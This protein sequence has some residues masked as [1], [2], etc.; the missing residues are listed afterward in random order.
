M[1]TTAFTELNWRSS[2]FN[3]GSFEEAIKLRKATVPRVFQ[4]YP[5]ESMTILSVTSSARRIVFLDTG[6]RYRHALVATL[7]SQSRKASCRFQGLPPITLAEMAPQ[8][9]RKQ[10]GGLVINKKNCDFFA[11]YAVYPSQQ[12][13]STK[14]QCS[15]QTAFN[16]AFCSPA[17]WVI[18]LFP[19]F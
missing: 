5:R 1:K 15:I 3:S 17:L 4:L 8:T 11:D 10:A 7:R 9:L 19:A 16:Y 2:A 6:R 14:V 18:P 12:R 13:W